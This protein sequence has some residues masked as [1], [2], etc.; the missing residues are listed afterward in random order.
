MAYFIFN[1]DTNDLYKIAAS[2]SVM[3]DNKGFQ[4]DHV[5]IIDV[6]D[7]DF[8]NYK[9]HETE[10]SRNGDNITWT[11][12]NPAPRFN[13]TDELQNYIDH[14]SSVINEWLKNSSNKPM[15]S[16]V[17]AYR[18]YIQNLDVDSI[19][20]NPSADATWTESTNS[21]SDGTALE[22]SLEKY[23]TDQGQTSYHIFELL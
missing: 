23:V 6:S 4:N 19:I 1:K 12:I 13:F 7:S 18:D 14:I 17:I 20:T 15:A 16:S 8:N 21:Y 22:S 2:Q 10:A 11:T 3:D 9:N 5:D